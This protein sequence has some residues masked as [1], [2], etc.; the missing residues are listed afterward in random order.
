MQPVRYRHANLL[1][2]METG[3]YVVAKTH[4]KAF[5]AFMAREGSACYGVRQI[6]AR[7]LPFE[8][9][10]MFFVPLV[11]VEHHCP[12]VYGYLSQPYFGATKKSKF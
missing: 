9:H 5:E 3:K 11:E 2:N 1:W 12:P 7:A 10:P 4:D 6:L 8:L